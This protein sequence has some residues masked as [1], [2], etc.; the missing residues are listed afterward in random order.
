MRILVTL[1]ERLSLG[2][3]QREQ[4]PIDTTKAFDFLRRV[5]HQI[6][7]PRAQT[8]HGADF[9]GAFGR[10]AR[11]F[12]FDEK[13]QVAFGLGLAAGLTTEQDDASRMKTLDDHLRD[14]TQQFE[15]GHRLP[16]SPY[17]IAVSATGGVRP[18]D[19]WPRQIW[20]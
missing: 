18:T 8:E 5:N 6:H 7:R 11:S 16:A 15:I 17:H 14:V 2:L 19:S 13:V 12:H 10:A 20:L 3:G 1:I 9:H 4:R